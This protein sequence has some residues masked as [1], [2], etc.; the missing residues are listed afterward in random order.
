MNA[1]R[2]LAGLL[3][4]LTLFAGSEASAQSCTTLVNSQFSWIQ[5]SSA[6]YITV[7]GVSLKPPSGAVGPVASYFT[8]MLSGYVAPGWV[9]NPTT[10]VF[11]QT[12]ARL[13][14]TAN[15]GRQSF[16]DRS[17]ISTYASPSRWQNFS[18]FAMDNIQLELDATGKMTVIL[19]SWS[20][21]RVSVVSPT[22]SGNVLTGFVGTSVYS[23][24]FEQLDLI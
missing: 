23:F 10:G 7:T 2:I 19:N 24:T 21:T 6:N 22:C 18:A 12:P 14:S 1:F 17:Y 15:S 16:N 4:S 5:A 3:L 11:T 9:Y 20:N 13:T 8:G